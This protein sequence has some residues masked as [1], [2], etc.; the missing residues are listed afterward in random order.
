MQRASRTIGRNI[1]EQDVS[2][3]MALTFD[4][5]GHVGVA[6]GKLISSDHARFSRSNEVCFAMGH[7][8]R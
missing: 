1:P 3:L 2:L 4:C 7:E 8:G 5:A 6:E